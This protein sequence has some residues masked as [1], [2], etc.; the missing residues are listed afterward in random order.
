MNIERFKKPTDQS[1]AQFALSFSDGRCSKK[2]LASM[3]GMCLMVIDRLYDNGDI[4][5]KSQKEI[6]IES[7]QN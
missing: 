3:I 4:T 6:D 1:V 7:R 2:Q 5:I